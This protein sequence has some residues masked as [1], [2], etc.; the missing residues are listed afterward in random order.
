MENDSEKEKSL[1]FGKVNSNKL[2]T[3]QVLQI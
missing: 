3:S 2:F 1:V